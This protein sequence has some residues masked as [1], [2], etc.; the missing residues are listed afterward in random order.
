MTPEAESFL[1]TAA[2]AAK[3]AAHPYPAIA[4]CEAALE[5]TWGKSR[6]AVEG[7]NL[8]G[9]KAPFGW[10]RT[11]A[12]QIPTR[13]F[14]QGKWVTV[15]ALW[16]RYPTQAACFIDRLDTLRFL[17][18]SYPFYAAALA[19]PTP[20]EFITNVSRS[21]STDPQRAAKVLSIYHE[22]AVT[23]KPFI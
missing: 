1:L 6:L 15:M 11:E 16:K 3:A 14:L 7:N 17:S 19:S 18:K 9:L 22:Y 8:F 12:L 2:A 21:W 10:L 20:E 23:L 4:A 13:E 5:S